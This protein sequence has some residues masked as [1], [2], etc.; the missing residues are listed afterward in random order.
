MRIIQTYWNASGLPYNQVKGG[1]LSPEIHWMSWALSCTLLRRFYD[2]VELYTTE[3]DAKIFRKFKIPYT[4][5]HT[6][7]DCEFIRNLR[8][9]MWAYAK[10]YTYSIQAEPFL[11]VDGDVFI[12]K[13]FKEELFNGDI[14]VQNIEENLGVYHKS[15]ETLLNTDGAFVPDWIYENNDYPIA[16][17]M[18][19]FGANDLDFVKTYCDFAFEYY[20]KNGSFFVENSIVDPNLNILPEQ[21]LLYV[22]SHKCNM[23][24]KTFVP[25]IIRTDSEFRLFANYLQV[26]FESQFLHLLGAFKKNPEDN[27]FISYVLESEAKD[28]YDCIVDDFLCSNEKDCYF[29]GT[30]VKENVYNPL[31][32]DIDIL[33][34]RN[35]N[36]HFEAIE[37]VRSELRRLIKCHD[38]KRKKS[39]VNISAC[40]FPSYDRFFRL[41][42]ENLS[43]H[44]LCVNPNHS[45]EL[46]TINYNKIICNDYIISMDE[47]Y[48]TIMF[49][50]MYR[51]FIYGINRHIWCDVFSLSLIECLK[52]KP[53]KIHDLLPM[54]KKD[55]RVFSIVQ[56]LYELGVL[57]VSENDVPCIPASECY[58]SFINNM[59]NNGQ[60]IFT[61]CV[62]LFGAMDNQKQIAGIK[63]EN[64]MFSIYRSLKDIGIG[65]NAVS[66]DL[67]CTSTPF[68]TNINMS[69]NLTVFVLVLD[70]ERD[71][72]KVYN[73]VVNRVEY[74]NE[75][76]FM[77]LW[78][79]KAIIIDK[80]NT[81]CKK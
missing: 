23:S 50:L 1:W 70:K 80:S 21:Y 12:W 62:Y 17:N 51:D 31:Q 56:S 25:N 59:K 35:S 24:V 18:G 40:P 73:P 47:S 2:D 54:F 81:F 66:C 74:C 75:Q 9:E 72:Y 22:M 6:D 71:S 48:Y 61:Q 14:C 37:G 33:N 55:S 32:I 27:E 13:P 3:E 63:V 44:N 43:N 20:Q 49:S 78:S 42:N 19:I 60:N 26:P 5:I 52:T 67:F 68:I 7:L 28:L 8:P 69:Q 16:Y 46:T 65:V 11:H 36:S 53:E 29:L 79:G 58:V 10:I 57:Y 15:I 41:I 76:D 4:K 64:N 39:F 45:I 77:R 38:E 30:A 34:D